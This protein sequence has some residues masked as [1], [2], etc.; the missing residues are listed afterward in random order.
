M[1]YHFQ[2]LE[3]YV[4]A[5]KDDMMEEVST[6]HH[7]HRPVGVHGNLH[8]F[9]QRAVIHT[10][11]DKQAGIARDSLTGFWTVI[12]DWAHI[13]GS[14]LYVHS[15]S[16]K[17][18][19]ADRTEQII[20]LLDGYNL[21]GVDDQVRV[22]TRI[23]SGMGF[24][25]NVELG[26][27]VSLLLGTPE[28]PEA[29]WTLSPRVD[30]NI[31]KSAYPLNIASD[32]DRKGIDSYLGS[33]S[34]EA[35]D[36][37]LRVVIDEVTSL[38]GTLQ[39]Q[40]ILS[41]LTTFDYL[42]IPFGGSYAGMGS[43]SVLAI[44][45]LAD[46]FY[47][48]ATMAHLLSS[49]DYHVSALLY[50]SQ[51]ERYQKLSKAFFVLLHQETDLAHIMEHLSGRD[52]GIFQ[53]VVDEFYAWADLPEAEETFITE[54][55]TEVDRDDLQEYEEIDLYSDILDE[56][57][58]DLNTIA[59]G[60]LSQDF[61][62]LFR[63]KSIRLSSLIE[64][65]ATISRNLGAFFAKIQGVGTSALSQDRI[66]LTDTM[67]QRAGNL[68]VGPF[69]TPRNDRGLLD[70]IAL[71]HRS[72]V[73]ETGQNPCEGFFLS[74]R[75]ANK[76]RNSIR[77]VIVEP[78]DLREII[79][80]EEIPV[81][82]NTTA[83]STNNMISAGG[84][85]RVR[86]LIPSDLGYGVG[87]RIGKL[88]RNTRLDP[89]AEDDVVQVQGSEFERQTI[90]NLVNAV[91]T[92]S[93]I[94]F[95]TVVD[96]RIE[97]FK[98]E[99]DALAGGILLA[100]SDVDAE[101]NVSQV[102]KGKSKPYGL[103]YD[104][105]WLHCTNEEDEIRMTKKLV[106]RPISRIP[107]PSG[108]FGFREILPGEGAYISTPLRDSDTGN[109]K[110][111]E[112]RTEYIVTDTFTN[113]CLTP[114]SPTTRSRIIDVVIDELR[115]HRLTRPLVW[116]IQDV[117]PVFIERALTERPWPGRK[118]SFS[119]KYFIIE[120]PLKANVLQTEQGDVDKPEDR[121]ATTVANVQD[122]IIDNENQDK[123]DGDVVQGQAGKPPEDPDSPDPDEINE[124]TTDQ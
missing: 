71:P 36:H 123:A 17:L 8:K 79:Q 66:F 73:F 56:D 83:L 6:I 41:G 64:D 28:I 122:K 37:A 38:A 89:D 51:L 18:R 68:A 7:L 93:A 102:L 91:I 94:D 1:R 95:L 4:D 82:A 35:A 77:E 78:A 5:W 112:V 65:D 116:K 96:D 99:I 43:G 114:H 67:Q 20:K 70:K 42:T 81:I 21:P 97:S 52:P 44:T 11:L 22:T 72:G 32:I 26:E 76:L 115:S 40:A 54:I 39:A 117:N 49:A 60:K 101:E 87:Y 86:G 50:H 103:T 69:F 61:R 100:Y 15:T 113:V 33:E 63:P 10:I 98:P 106:V 27:A 55:M 30:A 119:A 74:L 53:K 47:G 2:S 104:E 19:P 121:L 105:L 45:T 107:V 57:K 46:G 14:L 48:L 109:L 90:V 108:D 85:A 58:F 59:L 92:T 16:G 23:R 12:R 84:Y 24:G 88:E 110:M 31:S 34:P 75:N 25:T 111:I 80:N 120:F 9:F 3:G 62:R 118:S 13:M 29:D 124:E